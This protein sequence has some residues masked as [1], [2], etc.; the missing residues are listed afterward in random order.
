MKRVA[1]KTEEAVAPRASARWAAPRFWVCVGLLAL[2][3][4]GVHLLP[5]LFKVYF[6]K[7]PIELKR[8]LALFDVGKL[9][10]RYE[11]NSATDEIPPLSEDALDSLGTKH[12]LHIFVTD[13]QK[14]PTDVTRIARVFVTYYTGQPDMVPHVPD[15]CFQ[16]GGYDK[17]G[18]ETREIVVHGVGAPGDLLP[19]RVVR[20]VASQRT[21]A[22]E[23]GTQEEVVLYFFSANG[24]YVTTRNGVRLRL[25]SPFERYAYYAKIEVSFSDEARLRKAGLEDS[26]AAMGPLM[27][28]VLPVLF[29]D[30]FD[31]EKL[32]ADGAAAPESTE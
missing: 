25:S 18:A 14:S 22:V 8:K 1:A 27:E 20:F 16:A 15:E 32:A 30:H 12:L 24:S 19:V 29:E 4:L 17:V 10:P 2:A 7:E 21:R 31:L 6:Q 9:G 3:A 23:V 11:R 5:P 13:T 26:V 28:A